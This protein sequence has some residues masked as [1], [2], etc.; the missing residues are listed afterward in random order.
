M[1]RVIGAGLPRTATHSLRNALPRLTGGACYHMLDVNEHPE[2]IAVWHAASEG[3]PPDWRESFSGG[4]AAV[5]WPAS[6]F[7]AASPRSSRAR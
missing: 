4:G 1:L 5:D 2:H 3:S 7:W 6:A